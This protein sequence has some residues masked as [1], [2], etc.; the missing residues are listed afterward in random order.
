[1]FD[2]ILH[3]RHLGFLFLCLW[4]LYIYYNSKL[5]KFLCFPVPVF[6]CSNLNFTHVKIYPPCVYFF[7]LFEL[8]WIGKLLCVYVPDNV[9]I[10]NFLTGSAPDT[11]AVL[12][13]SVSILVPSFQP[14]VR[15]KE[16]SISDHDLK[17]I[18]QFS[19]SFTL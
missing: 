15:S 7:L 4:Q 17:Q 10:L 18:E 3:Y 12:I 19:F 1:M 2:I 11:E 8:L 13:K 16:T 5:I 9:F 6:S 14:Y